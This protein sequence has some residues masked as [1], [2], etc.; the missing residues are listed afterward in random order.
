MKA[1]HYVLIG[2]GTIAGLFAII[3]L[4]GFIWL[5]TGPEGGV[6]LPN[7]MEDYAKKYLKRHQVLDGSEELLA[8]Y[9]A[10]ISMDGSEA[11]ILTTKRVIHHKN[12]DNTTID[13]AEIDDVQHRNEPLI[14]DVFEI[15]ANSGKTI[16]L[17]IAPLN[18]GQTFKNVLM[19]AWSNARKKDRKKK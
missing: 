11:A 8:Y 12:G 10:T 1:T 4:A 5:L 16:K 7:E 13:L 6:R 9:D 3:I 19:K 14:G 15:S 18:Q 2:C 17:E